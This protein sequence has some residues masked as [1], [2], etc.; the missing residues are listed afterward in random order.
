MIYFRNFSGSHRYREANVEVLSSEAKPGKRS[1]FVFAPNV[2]RRNAIARK[3][4]LEAQRR[5]NGR[6]T[7]AKER[8]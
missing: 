2:E 5:Q 8:E 4:W 1:G 6:K 7:T 3:Y